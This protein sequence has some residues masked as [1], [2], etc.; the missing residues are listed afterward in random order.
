MKYGRDIILVLCALVCALTS[1]VFLVEYLTAREEIERII[2]DL[3]GPAA[4]KQSMNPGDGYNKE[5]R[6]NLR[7]LLEKPPAK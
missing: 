2:A 3:R 4:N 5:A 1:A 6:E 7:R